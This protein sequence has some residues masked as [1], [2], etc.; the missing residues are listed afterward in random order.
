M[1]KPAIAK[2]FGKEMYR[3]EEIIEAMKARWARLKRTGRFPNRTL[4]RR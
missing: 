3:D 4:R 1:T 2:L